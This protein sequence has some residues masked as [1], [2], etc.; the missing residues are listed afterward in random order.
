MSLDFSLKLLNRG[1][2]D[3]VCPASLIKERL[4]GNDCLDLG[5][6][7][8]WCRLKGCTSTVLLDCRGLCVVISLDCHND[9]QGL[10]QG[11]FGLR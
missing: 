4:R 1:L 3:R 5:R 10:R 7:L 8:T 9:S 11:L 2:D 6:C